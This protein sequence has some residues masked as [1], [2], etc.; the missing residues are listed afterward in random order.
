MSHEKTCNDYA[1]MKIGRGTLYNRGRPIH[2]VEHDG[3]TIFQGSEY[4]TAM[5]AAELYARLK[6]VA[7][8]RP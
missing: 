3:R 1:A 4:E 5:F 8:E 2:F 6:K 7:E